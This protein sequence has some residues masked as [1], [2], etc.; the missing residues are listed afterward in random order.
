MKIRTKIAQIAVLALAPI[1]AH[2][3][4]MWLAGE[5]EAPSTSNSNNLIFCDIANNSSGG[6]NQSTSCSGQVTLDV[7]YGVWQGIVAA[8]GAQ[9]SASAQVGSLKAYAEADGSELPHVQGGFFNLGS[10][11]WVTASFQD[12]VD[13][14]PP[15]VVPGTPGFTQPVFDVHGPVSA[16]GNPLG[17][18]I[19]VFAMTD[20]NFSASAFGD[21]ATDFVSIANGLGGL[22]GFFLIDPTGVTSVT[23]TAQG[24]TLTSTAIPIIFGTPHPFSAHLESTVSSCGNCSSLTP[25][26]LITFSGIADLS[27]TANLIGFIITD[28]SGN[29][30]QGSS[31]TGTGGFD[32]NSLGGSAA[33]PEPASLPLVGGVMLV[34]LRLRRRRPYDAG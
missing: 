1:A 3:A 2:G 27:H 34:L 30:L 6:V 14:L 23:G 16:S 25:S 26:Q 4:T 5:G 31:I 11:A 9:I 24:R 19:G 15:G 21:Q 8:G 10:S 20:L 28:A 33:A 29:P 18:S 32:Y 7:K 12:M 17:S 22:T 13:V